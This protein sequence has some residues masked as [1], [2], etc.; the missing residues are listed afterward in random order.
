MKKNMGDYKEG[1]VKLFNSFKKRF[2]LDYEESLEYVDNI[3]EDKSYCILYFTSD[4]TYTRELIEEINL[5]GVGSAYG[6][7]RNM[8][9]TLDD[10]REAVPKV[11]GDGGNKFIVVELDDKS[12]FRLE[13]IPKTTFI[14]LCRRC[15]EIVVDIVRSREYIACEDIHRLSSSD[16]VEFNNM[17]RNLYKMRREVRPKIF[18]SNYKMSNIQ[19][20]VICRERSDEGV[21]VCYR[22]NKLVGFIVYEN[23]SDKTNTG[24]EFNYDIYVKDLFVLEEYRRLGIATRLFKEVCRYADRYR[25]TSVRFRNW[26]FDE[27]VEKFISSLNKKVLYT[28]YEIEL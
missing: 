20:E 9:D 12:K 16:T 25:F 8:Y 23:V 4:V 14:K 2:G 11:I 10:I 15:G 13:D 26:A 3:L 6:F 19:M 24:I 22:D 5:S 18:M 7:Y 28:T 21:F 1:L 17:Y 27:D